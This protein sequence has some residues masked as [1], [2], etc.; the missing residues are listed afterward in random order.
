MV[1]REEGQWLDAMR[2]TSGERDDRP[3]RQPF[4]I[5]GGVIR[6]DHR[7]LILVLASEDREGEASD[8]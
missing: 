2:T 7:Y 1:I 8:R 6:N 3:Q 5:L 4:Q